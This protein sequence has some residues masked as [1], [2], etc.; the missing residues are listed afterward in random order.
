[1]KRERVP[2]FEFEMPYGKYKGFKLGDLWYQDMDYMIWSAKNLQDTVG[3]RIREFI[4]KMRELDRL[5]GST[6]ADI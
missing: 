5:A 1:M 4:D 3:K 2:I 6:N